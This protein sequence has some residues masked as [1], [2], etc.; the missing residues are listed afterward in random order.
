MNSVTAFRQVADQ[1]RQFGRVIVAGELEAREMIRGAASVARQNA[2]K[3]GARESQS[4]ADGLP[5]PGHAAAVQ[6]ADRTG[7]APREFETRQ[8]MR[9]TAFSTGGNRWVCLCVSR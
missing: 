1:A 9:A 3:A 8:A 4:F 5:W 2:M 6:R 7:G